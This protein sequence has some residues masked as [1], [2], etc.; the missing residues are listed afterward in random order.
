MVNP[1]MYKVSFC[2]LSTYWF[3]MELVNKA[4]V[5]TWHEKW[6]LALGWLSFT[7]T[8]RSGDGREMHRFQYQELNFSKQR[9]GLDGYSVLKVEGEKY[10]HVWH[11]SVFR[12]F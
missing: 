11:S 9:A 10:F 12:I 1:E 7:S 5:E 8:V 6:R 3:D 2:H 4:W